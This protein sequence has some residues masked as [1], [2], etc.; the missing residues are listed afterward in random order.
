[1]ATLIHNVMTQQITSS[2]LRCNHVA[3]PADQKFEA[4]SSPGEWT[5]LPELCQDELARQAAGQD[6]QC[7]G[8]Q[9]R[10]GETD[11]CPVAAKA[12]P[13]FARRRQAAR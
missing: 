4:Q 6:R 11:N 13:H 1:M 3:K 10:A 9:T 7:D 12:Q 8:L 5:Q 2:R